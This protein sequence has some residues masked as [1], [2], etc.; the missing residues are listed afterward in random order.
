MPPVKRI[1]LWLVVVFLLYAI[2]TSPDSAADIFGSA[3]EVV[4]N[5]VRNIG[6][7]FDSLLQG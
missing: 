7:F 4:A 5:G 1:V 6:R 2:L 3:W